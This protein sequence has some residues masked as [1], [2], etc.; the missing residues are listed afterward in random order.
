MKVPELYPFQVGELKLVKV[1]LALTALLIE[2]TLP[3]SNDQLVL[4][5]ATNNIPTSPTEVWEYPLNVILT[6]LIAVT[7]PEIVNVI[8]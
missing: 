6:S 5:G 1:T 2:P 3:D 7:K 8:G 4:S